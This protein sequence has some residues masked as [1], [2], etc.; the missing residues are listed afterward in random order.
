MK[1]RQRQVYEYILKRAGEGSSPSLREICREA[2]ISSTSTAA[3]YVDSLV[4]I[5]LL[6]RTGDGSRNIR[7]AGD[8]AARVPIIGR[9]SKGRPVTDPE[10]VEEYVYFCPPRSLSGELFARRVSGEELSGAGI[11]PGDI[12][13][14]VTVPE[15][16]N[17]KN[18]SIVLAAFDGRS[19]LRR[20]YYEN[21]HYR[22]EADI[23]GGTEKSS[24]VQP[25]FLERCT[26][27]GRL[28]GIV[29]YIGWA[30]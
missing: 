15:G 20:Y 18:G 9:V 13:V 21:G 17:V 24:H 10:E 14:L 25:V 5:G 1:E 22:L 7:P 23:S 29:R 6:T 27:V 8:M 26:V 12:A 4:E 11:L 28:A 30:E 3:R 19:C 16:S 2:G